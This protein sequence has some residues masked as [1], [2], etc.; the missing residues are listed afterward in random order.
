M[1][2][3]ARTYVVVVSEK[4][5][6]MPVGKPI[7]FKTLQEVV[8]YMSIHDGNVLKVTV[9]IVKM[10]K[11]SRE[12][13]STWLKAYMFANDD[14]KIALAD[15]IANYLDNHAEFK[16]HSRHI[17]RDMARTEG[18]I[19]DNLEADDKFQDL[20]L[21]V[22]HFTTHSFTG[23]TGL[24]KLIENQNGKAYLKTAGFRLQQAPSPAPV[25]P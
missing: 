20:V 22:F 9:N 4:L 18:L 15:S 14:K 3:T 17:D 7:G 2:N 12:L 11:L 5:P 16:D 13:V 25:N 6:G 23:P 10:I 1:I 21:S 19:V 8:G 24:V